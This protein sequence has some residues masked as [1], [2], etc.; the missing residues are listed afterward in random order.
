[1]KKQHVQHY[2]YVGHEHALFDAEI[3]V[4]DREK[5]FLDNQPCC[6]SKTVC[7]TRIYVTGREKTAFAAKIRCAGRQNRF[8]A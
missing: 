3:N 4:T 8:K 2:Q 6:R 1:M 5:L 7:A